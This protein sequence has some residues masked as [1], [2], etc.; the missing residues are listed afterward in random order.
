MR[1]SFLLIV[2]HFALAVS[3]NLTFWPE[4][5]PQYTI[6]YRT[7][8]DIALN[9]SID[10]VTGIGVS[11][12]RLVFDKKGYSRRST[13]DVITLLN[14]GVQTL[15]IDLYWNQF[16]GKWQLCPVPFAGNVTTN[17][18]EVKDFSWNGKVARCQAS[19]TVDYL[20]QQ[21]K[22]YFSST[23]SRLYVTILELMFNLHLISSDPIDLE[24]NVDDLGSYNLIYDQ[25]E[26]WGNATLTDS[27]EPILGSLLRPQD[28]NNTREY[29]STSQYENFYNSTAAGFPSLRSFLFDNYKRAVAMVISNDSVDSEA[30]YDIHDKDG[31]TVFLENVNFN[32][33]V[34]STSNL[35]TYQD[36][37]LS[38]QAREKGISQ[39]LEH[40]S[41]QT[42]FRTI[43]DNNLTEFSNRTF[44]DYKRCGYTPILNASHYDVYSPDNV[45]VGGKLEYIMN[46]FLP[47]SFWT[48]SER[49]IVEVSDNSRSNSSNFTGGL[50]SNNNEQQANS[51]EKS[52]RCVSLGQDGFDV[53][54]CYMPLNYA[55][56]SKEVP[57]DWHIDRNSKRSYFAFSSNKSC[58]SGYQFGVPL[59]SLEMLALMR[60]VEDNGINGHVWVDLNDI[61]VPNC[62]VS[63]GPYASCPYKKP[64][65]RAK[66][67]GLSAPSFIVA[68]VI[69]ALIF[70]EKFFRSIPIITNRRRHWRSVINNYYKTYEYE[71]VPS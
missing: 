56:Q 6:A 23:N 63:N 22:N 3:Y 69:L 71:G 20:M 53:G 39:E 1:N 37:I 11:L 48:W 32:A 46:N 51:E 41:E 19:F 65:S 27:L 68:G 16:T 15:M 52:V 4:K 7:Q 57:F 29:L 21:I 24:G 70:F 2:V 28:I 38:I 60:H 9:V 50:L 34:Q 45:D 62:F 10:E 30:A 59:L 25:F 5:P 35:S 33:F 49:N 67:V 58:P 17:A 13:E 18:T 40:F 44:N 8:R 66:L 54:D 43:V 61:T 42:H 64:E 36:C 55:C 47:Q 31:G 26:D 14:S 12:N